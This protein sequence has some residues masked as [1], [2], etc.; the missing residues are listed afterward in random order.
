MTVAVRA[1]VLYQRYME[2][3]TAMTDCL[4]I[5][6]HLA[7]QHLIRAAVRIVYRVKA[8]GSDT[9]SAALALIIIN[10]CLFIHVRNRVAS[11]LLCATMTAAA[12]LLMNRRLSARMLLHLSGTASAA[13]TNILQGTA[14]AGRLMAL[15]MG[16]ADK[17]ICVHDRMSDQRRLAVLT[18]YDR[19]LDL[20]RSAQSI[21]DQDLTSGGNTVESV[22]VRT[23]QM[24]QRIL[25]ASRVKRIAVSQKWHT[26]LLLTQ[27]CYCFRIVRTQKSQI[28][29]LPKMHLDRNKLSIHVDVLDSRCNTQLFQLIQLA[30]PD[31]TA[32]ISKINR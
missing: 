11:T 26:T 8:A 22:Q 24:L 17:N 7:I 29:K 16:Q 4:R 10:D 20:I 18:I 27:I 12:Q 19:Y 9:S 6:C 3:R 25:S 5:L 21:S 1:D 15:K 28:S 2:A 13:H 23:L 31:R 32:K 30:C 14:K